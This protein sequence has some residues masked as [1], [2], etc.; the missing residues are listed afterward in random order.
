MHISVIV[1][2]L[3]GEQFLAEALQSIGAQRFP[4]LDIIVVDGGS[5]DR[6]IAIAQSFPGLR[7]I[8]QKGLGLASARNQGLQ[9]VPADHLIA[10][11]DADDLWEASK[12][13]V[14]TAYLSA[15]PDCEAVTG[16]LVRFAQPGC[17]IPLQY[18][19]GWL[20]R[21]VPAYT[22]GG[23]LIRPSAFRHVGD[24]NPAL[25]VGCDHD[26]FAR[27]K[28]IGLSLSVLPQ[29]VLRKRIHENNLSRNL[30]VYQ[31]ELLRLTRQSL[32]RRTAIA[33]KSK[34][35]F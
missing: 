35:E 9:A 1:V 3:N 16:H 24:F 27:A 33:Q 31:R 29:I 21:P 32:A 18:H 5:C 34:S 13:S 19:D 23:F 10:F 25:T 4:S 30:T 2:V 11:L 6:S 15:H 17:I 7:V 20:N 28:D 26:W 8:H 14:Q 12:L 22:L